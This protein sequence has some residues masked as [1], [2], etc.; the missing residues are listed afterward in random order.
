[1][2]ESRQGGHNFLRAPKPNTLRSRSRLAEEDRG[3]SK[4]SHSQPCSRAGSIEPN[5]RGDRS[6]SVRTIRSV[7]SDVDPAAWAQVKPGG[8]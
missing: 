6:N 1:M 8:S 2:R 5:E 3:L 7:R 4:A